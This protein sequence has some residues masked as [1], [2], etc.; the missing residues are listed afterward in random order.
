MNRILGLG[1]AALLTATMACSNDLGPADDSG[2]N[3]DTSAPIGGDGEATDPTGE[4]RPTEEPKD[5]PPPKPDADD[6]N[7]PRDEDPRDEEPT[8]PPAPAAVC[9]NGVAEEGEVCDGG[10]LANLDCRAAGYAGGAGVTCTS[11]CGDV[12]ATSCQALQATPIAALGQSINVSDSLDAADPTWTRPS[13]DCAEGFGGGHHFD[14]HAIVNNT[15]A[16]QQIRI[17]ADWGESDGYLHVFA[18]PWSPITNSGCMVGNDDFE[19]MNASLLPDVTIAPGQQLIVVASAFSADTAFGAYGLNIETLTENA[20][21][22]VVTDPGTDPGTGNESG[23]GNGVI[24]E[25][26]VCDGSSLGGVT[27]GEMGYDFG[28]VVCAASCTAFVDFCFN[29]G[30]GGDDPTEPTNPVDPVDNATPVAAPGLTM[31]LDGSLGDGNEQWTRPNE[32]CEA[33]STTGARFESHRITNDSSATRSLDLVANWS[34]D[35]F[36]AV[37]TEDFDP[38]NAATG[39]LAADDDFSANSISMSSRTGSKIEDLLIFPGETLVVVAT[40]FGSDDKIGNYTVDVTS[41]NNGD[42][43]GVATIAPAGDSLI[44]RG[45]IHAND[46]TWNRAGNTCDATASEGDHYFDAVRIT[47]DSGS[48]KDLEVVATWGAGDGYLHAFVFDAAADGPGAG[49]CLAANDDDSGSGASRLSG[50]D[51]WSGETLV[52]VASTY[53]AETAIGAYQLEVKTLQ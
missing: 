16:A 26:E 22:P 44:T 45:T 1:F 38:A 37:Y 15:G 48:A 52:V 47:N 43:R 19:G 17:S 27:C 5:E 30:G 34:G 41:K 9:G 33:A 42:D 2:N 4:E 12:N 13:A 40:T 49:L 24:E 7:D 51:I 14:A 25:G 50:L 6:N 20:E 35:G 32:S 8:E 3:I 29:L 21:P 31:Q 28:F 10:D 53:S 18:S 11:S 46:G 23:C 39:C 36:L